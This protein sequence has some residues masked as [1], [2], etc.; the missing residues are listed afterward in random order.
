[1][2]IKKGQ[3]IETYNIG[4]SLLYYLSL[5]APSVFSNVYC[6]IYLWLSLR[7]S[8]TFIHF[9]I[10]SLF[11]CL[12]IVWHVKG[13]NNIQFSVYR[14]RTYNTMAK[15]TRTKGQ[16]T[17]Y[18]TKDLA[19]NKQTKYNKYPNAVW[20]AQLLHYLSRSMNHAGIYCLNG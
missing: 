8:L 11:L 14:R 15:R 9:H 2:T 10:L 12:K 16:T 13:R 18:K 7:Y 3:F 6:I 4:Y 5:I 17:I 1:V 20:E 19:N